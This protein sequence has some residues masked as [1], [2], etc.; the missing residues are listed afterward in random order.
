M[1]VKQTF[2]IRASFLLLAEHKV[3]AKETNLDVAEEELTPLGKIFAPNPKVPLKLDVT[4]MISKRFHAFHILNLIEKNQAANKRKSLR[5]QL[6]F[7]P[8]H[9]LPEHST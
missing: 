1:S 9:A 8:Q 4:A 7:P 3:G 5:W 2:E 6:L